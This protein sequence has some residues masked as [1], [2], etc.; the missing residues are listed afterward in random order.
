[1][2]PFFSDKINILFKPGYPTLAWVVIR[3]GKPVTQLHP[4]KTGW[5]REQ[6]IFDGLF[7][8]NELHVSL[9]GQ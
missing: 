5:M 9:T 6:F 3:Q 2:D 4:G 8:F 7:E 1:M